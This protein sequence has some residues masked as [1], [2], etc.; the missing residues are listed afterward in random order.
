M[1]RLRGSWFGV[2]LALVA[3]VKLWL[4]APREILAIF[5]PHDDLWQMRAA[6]AFYWL[7]PYDNLT[8][9]HLPIYPLFV[10]V[11]SLTGI[12][13][14]VA[15]EATYILG[16]LSACLALL[17]LGVP[18]LLC[19]LL[20]ALIVLHPATLTL[21]D[22]SLAEMLYGPLV[23]FAAGALIRILVPRDD[24][25]LQ[26]AVFAFV[27]GCAWFC[28]KESIIFLAPAGVLVVGLLLA[29]WRK[30]LPRAEVKALAAAL[31]LGPALMIV[32]MST[33]FSGLNWARYG[34]YGVTD[35][36]G[37]EYRRAYRAL[38]SIDAPPYKPYVPV[39]RAAM[40]KAYQVS[41]A[42]RELRPYFDGPN[43]HNW[44]RT[45]TLGMG[46]AFDRSEGEIGAGW[47]YW[48]LRD[49]VQAAGHQKRP[50]DAE[51]FYA[52][53][54]DEIEAAI[55]AGTIPSRRILTTFIDPNVGE[56]APRLP[57]SI[58]RTWGML[59]STDI[60]PERPLTPVDMHTAHVFDTAARR[61]AS[62]THGGG[63]HLEGWVL[64]PSPVSSIQLGAS[65]DA[66]FPGTFQRTERPDLKETT[67][68]GRTLTPTGYRIAAQL[69][70]ASPDAAVI[71]IQLADGS[72]IVT[73]PLGQLPVRTVLPLRTS[74]DAPAYLA[75]D[76]IVR[77][78][79]PVLQDHPTFRMIYTQGYGVLIALAVGLCALSIVM[80]R[81]FRM[82]WRHALIGGALA[83]FVLA[84]TGVFVLLDASAWPVDLRYVYPV[85]PIV[86]VLLGVL[87]SRARPRAA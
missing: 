26:G 4:V 27:M 87:A 7:R 38:Q 25:L 51:A 1:S 2:A 84:R 42:A 45:S 74:A 47:F 8:I 78:K 85:T 41:A 76:Q 62:G 9:A 18:R 14:R 11:F 68:E 80:A 40:E 50:A 37:R 61:R 30:L 72:R 48:A 43:G 13:L 6:L 20:F 19:A 10:K 60:P 35:F 29:F 65:A 59:S 17:R 70:A 5:S 56:W 64:A 81:G 71:V 69:Q 75:V 83:S 34:F 49:A 57:Q 46:A 23:L 82:D 67:I 79:K 15:I 58:R 44:A 32:A 3:F 73:R 16:A 28:R 77:V 55:R 86:V 12:P 54:A 66:T 36:D 22:R 63:M 53:L 39:S 21:F 31:L 52:R 24:R 33:L